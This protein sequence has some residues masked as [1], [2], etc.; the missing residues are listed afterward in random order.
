LLPAQ[1]E[2]KGYLDSVADKYGVS[3]RMQFKVEVERFVWNDDSKR[4]TLFLKHLDSGVRTKHVCQVLFNCGGALVAPNP[5][6]FKGRESFKGH[7]FHS[8]QWRH[9]I[10]LTGKKVVVIGNGCTG[11]QI[12]ATLSRQ[13]A[14]AQITNI[15]RSKQWIYTSMDFEYSKFMQ[16]IFRYVPGALQLHRLHIYLY[17][18]QEYP[19]F[20]MD[21]IGNW[22]RESRRKAVES[23]MRSAAPARYHDMLIPDFEI[24]CKRRI[25]D[26]GYLKALH[27]PRVQLTNSPLLE[28]VPEGVR[29]EDGIIPADI[30]VCANGFDIHGQLPRDKVVGK[31]G[32]DLVDHW[33][34]YGGPSAYNGTAL[35]GFPNLFF[36]LGPNSGTGHT[37]AVL[38]MEK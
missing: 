5:A 28:F 24:G 4:W 22:L 9:D 30:I 23:Y 33:A 16:W 10:D 14:A 12:V 25:Y 18:E 37:S 3:Q 34:Q 36:I 38:P 32:E 21:A 27:D 8:T 15:V 17:A 1:R 7:V 20:R 19:T 29:T 35:A 11:V 31:H 13:G 26:S 2:L 6:V